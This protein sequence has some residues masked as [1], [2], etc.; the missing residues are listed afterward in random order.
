MVDKLRVP[1]RRC[2]RWSALY[3]RG[4]GRRPDRPRRR[5]QCLAAV[6]R[7]LLLSDLSP[8]IKWP[9]SLPSTRGVRPVR[10][11][12]ARRH[13]RIAWP[14]PRRAVPLRSTAFVATTTRANYQNGVESFVWRTYEA[15][16]PPDSL[17][18][19]IKREP[20]CRHPVLCIINRLY[21]NDRC[22]D[23]L[24]GRVPDAAL[25]STIRRCLL[26]SSYGYARRRVDC[27]QNQ[28][29]RRAG[30]QHY[31]KYYPFGTWPSDR[32]KLVWRVGDAMVDS[33]SRSY[34]PA[35]PLLV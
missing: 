23:H 9:V 7:P 25:A 22:V 1:V 15:T 13:P 18:M 20:R 16:L 5:R 12:S 34:P 3:V 10:G 14:I 21:L 29:G 31:S 30:A 33:T 19:D 28:S 11:H 2:S 6:V 27:L 24:R 8:T 17:D 4:L 32:G 26:R 35:Y